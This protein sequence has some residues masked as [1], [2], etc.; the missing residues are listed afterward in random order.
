M[1]ALTRAAVPADEAASFYEWYDRYLLW[2]RGPLL[3]LWLL[4]GRF[5]FP[6]HRAFISASPCMYTVARSRSASDGIDFSKSIACA[7][8]WTIVAFEVA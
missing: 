8:S 6:T 7:K 2:R 3:T 4:A 1:A 5:T